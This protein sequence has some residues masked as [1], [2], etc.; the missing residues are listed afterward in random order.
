MCFARES[1][2]W[3]WLPVRVL[4]EHV[5]VIQ[6]QSDAGKT[7]TILVTVGILTAEV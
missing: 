3:A 7:F 5:M 4:F 2:L 1:G 6:V